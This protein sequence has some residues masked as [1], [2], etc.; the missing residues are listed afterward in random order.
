[1]TAINAKKARRP[2]NAPSLRLHVASL[3]C[4]QLAKAASLSHGSAAEEVDDREKHDGTKE[5]NEQ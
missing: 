4:L 3:A 5:R 2:S 1:V